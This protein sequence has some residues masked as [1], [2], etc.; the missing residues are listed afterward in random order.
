MYLI[1]RR[2][3]N[4]YD[5]REYSMSDEMIP[6][7]VNNPSKKTVSEVL[8]IAIT[9]LSLVMVLYHLVYAYALFINVYMHQNMHLMLALVIIML[10]EIKKEI[11]SDHRSV[12]K[13]TTCI[14]LTTILVASIVG[15]IYVFT[16]GMSLVYR[17]G[18][19]TQMDII[20]GSLIII[21]VLVGCRRSVGWVLVI[22]AIVFFAYTV[23]G[24]LLP[25]SF[26][27]FRI[28]FPDAVVKFCIGLSGI[29]GDSMRISANYIFLF[30]VFGEFLAVAGGTTFFLELS[31]IIGKRVSC[32]SGITTLVSCGL[33]GM[34]T[35]SGMANASICGP[36]T[37]PLMK[38]S[39]YDDK[40]ISGVLTTAATGA[41]IVP[42]VMG[43]VA[44]VMA[45]YTGVSY[46][47]ICLISI[48]PCLL[49]YFC[50]GVYVV[51]AG[52]KRGIKRLGDEIKVDVKRLLSTCYMFLV[53]L[54]LIIVL[55]SL[56]LSLRMISFWICISVVVLSLFQKQT[57][58]PLKEWIAACRHGAAAGANIA[59]ASGAIGLV[60]GAFEAT[61]LG[62]RLPSMLI[63]WANG[64]LN[65]ALL[66]VAVVTIILG[67]GVPPFA[68]YMM[69]AM[70]CA[71]ILQKLGC[72]VLQ[73]HYFIFLFTVF[74]QMTP[75]VAVTAVAAAPIC[76]VSYLQAGIQA[77]KVGWL[78][79]IMP[80]FI[81]WCPALILEKASAME[82]IFGIVAII[83]MSVLLQSVNLNF[84]KTK[85]NIPERLMAFIAGVL[86][87][88]YCFEQNNI[89]FA[90]AVVLALIFW[91]LN[92]S[93]AKKQATTLTT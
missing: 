25:G 88:Y 81:I 22:M 92:A 3:P 65:L 77:V 74:G 86:F 24:H 63:E 10:S 37:V 17:A 73:A 78:A 2:A 5:R 46:A 29:Y 90:A 76:N 4:V 14:F 59:M 49:Y 85:L 11:D 21:A 91:Y 26:W 75:P 64:N 69:V 18:L 36:F 1:M 52:R 87:I 51:L 35:G 67:C 28:T 48:A 79:W 89:V 58:K 12:R 40:E 42:P 27:H 8:D 62:N 54:T 19:N 50:L 80:F 6:D 7:S 71:S 55:I 57:R 68:S 93:K 53:P 45:E 60:L 83:A 84:Y 56:N 38:G 31:K 16:Q 33:M 70:M 82:T 23:G 39:G 13:R 43:V 44:F 66:L 47:R 72:T 61:N 32:G 9:V 41:L 30:M 34:V 15:C 20:M